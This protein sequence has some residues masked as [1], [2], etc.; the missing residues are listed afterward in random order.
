MSI[1]QVLKYD[2]V[3]QKSAQFV[4]SRQIGRF[5]MKSKIEEN[6][7]LSILLNTHLIHQND[8]YKNSQS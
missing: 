2:G 4:D 8:H 5:S 1:A 7:T 6:F 3:I